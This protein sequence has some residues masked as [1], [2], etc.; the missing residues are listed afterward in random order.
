MSVFCKN[1]QFKSNQKYSI[2]YTKLLY[3]SDC[4]ASQLK[5]IAKAHQLCMAHLLR[6]L[7]NFAENLKSR[8][9]AEMKALFL[10]AIE[11]KKKMTQD[12]YLNPPEEVSKLNAELDRLLRTDFSKFHDKE[13]A[14]VKRLIKNRQS[15]FT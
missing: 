11:L 2:R 10:H 4:W 14:F 12:H 9:R 3:V 13:Q 5:V 6:E 1:F 8:W 15:I 7:T